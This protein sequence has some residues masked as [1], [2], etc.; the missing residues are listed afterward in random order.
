MTAGWLDILLAAGLVIL[1]GQSLRAKDLFV[2]VVLFMVFG[3]FMALAWVRMRAPDIAL[4]E[5]AIGSGLTG[6]LFLGYLSRIE[7]AGGDAPDE[8]HYLRGKRDLLKYSFLLLLAAVTA[9]FIRGVLA[10]PG[11]TSGPGDYIQAALSRS[12]VENPVTAVILNFRAYD[13]FLEIGVMFLVVIAA[14]ALA[15]SGPAC[16]RLYRHPPSRVLVMFLQ[17]LVPFM[18]VAAC[19]LLWAGG[20]APGGAFQAGAIL[21]AAGILMLLCGVPLN[22]SMESPW[23]RFALAVGFLGFLALGVVTMGEGKSFLEYPS[24]AVKYFI[25]GIELMATVSIA[26][27]LLSLFAG[28]AGFLR[29]GVEKDG[30]K[31]A[32]R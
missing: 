9:V 29:A 17:V 30:Q 4:V 3:I 14:H 13:T 6:A 8:D 16:A 11:R 22:L 23:G 20:H 21:A 7:G 24:E 18:V 28:C 27:I 31:G 5:A 12:G 1:A 19:Y 10:L 2:S 25:L 26:V 15:A 32:G